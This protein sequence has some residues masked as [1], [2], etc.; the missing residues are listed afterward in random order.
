MVIKMSKYDP[1]WE[2]VQKD[3]RTS[4]Q[5][6]FDEIQHIIGIPIDHSFLKYK[7]ELTAY[8][9]RVGKISLKGQTVVFDKISGKVR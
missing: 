5:L 2:Y 7:A 3:G 6:T 1:L 9:Y 4:F 8:G